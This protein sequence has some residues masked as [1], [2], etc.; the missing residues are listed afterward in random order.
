VEGFEQLDRLGQTLV[1][2]E[3]RRMS[4][5]EEILLEEHQKELLNPSNKKLVRPA[6]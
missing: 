4:K 2:N 6:Q 1:T 5:E 3:V